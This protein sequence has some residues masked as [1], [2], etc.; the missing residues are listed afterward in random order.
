MDGMEFL[1]VRI[2][3][4]GISLEEPIEVL[5]PKGT[6]RSADGLKGGCNP[7]DRMAFLEEQVQYLLD[8]NSRM[9]SL[10]RHL[11]APVMRELPLARQTVV[12][13]TS[14]GKNCPG[15]AG[16]GR[17]TLPKGGPRLCPPVHRPALSGFPGKS[18]IDVGCG[19]GR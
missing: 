14:S 5:A 6:R 15:A 12:V 18:V 10:L 17:R 4:G 11:A 8:E 7:E 19:A 9:T 1:M 13:S 16:T 3:E 2:P